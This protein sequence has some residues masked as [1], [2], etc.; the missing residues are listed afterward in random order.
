MGPKVRAACEYVE[1]TG[2]IAAIGSIDD[3]EGLLAGTAGTQ[4]MLPDRRDSATCSAAETTRA[5]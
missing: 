3:A 1:Q 5:V 4:V 2:G